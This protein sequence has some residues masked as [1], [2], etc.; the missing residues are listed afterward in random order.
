MY[1]SIFLAYYKF[2]LSFRDDLTDKAKDDSDAGWASGFVTLIQGIH[3][4]I[5]ILTLPLLG[6]PIDYS[7]IKIMV[8]LYSIILSFSNLLYFFSKS[9][10]RQIIE[11]DKNANSDKKEMNIF[12]AILTIVLTIVALIIVLKMNFRLHTNQNG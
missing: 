10:A 2:R 3:I 11:A 6:F 9:R 1:N 12:L 5:I 7:R 4:T 8:V